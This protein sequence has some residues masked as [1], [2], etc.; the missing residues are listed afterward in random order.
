MMGNFFVVTCPYL[1]ELDT[2]AC[3]ASSDIITVYDTIAR[4]RETTQILIDLFSDS[5]CLYIQSLKV[6]EPLFPTMFFP[7]GLI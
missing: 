4:I 7:T 5:G 3:S 1:F 6:L 2:V